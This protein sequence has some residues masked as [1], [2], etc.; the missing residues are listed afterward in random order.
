MA[1]V[2]IVFVA[3]LFLV[4]STVSYLT[5]QRK[6]LARG[7]SYEQPERSYW[8]PGHMRTRIVVDDASRGRG[9]IGNPT[10]ERRR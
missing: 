4:V 5:V 9:E 10:T 6:I 2:L 1:R 7:P 8:G 3:A